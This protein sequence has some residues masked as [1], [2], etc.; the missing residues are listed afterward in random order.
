MP[1]LEVDR[2]TAP[3][4]IAS[5]VGDCAAQYGI[6]IVPLCKALDLD[7]NTF[8][9]LTGRVSLDRLCRL[10]ETCALISGDEA[11]GLKCCDHFKP[12]ASGPYGYGLLS[13]PTALDFFRFLG[14]HQG[15]VASK[16]FCLFAMGPNGA[17]L[18]FSYSPLILKR[19]QYLDMVAGLIMARLRGILG[20]QI[21]AVEIGL[22]R[23][24]PRNPALYRERMSRR[25]SFGKRINTLRLPSELYAVPNPRGDERLFKLMDLQCRSLRP[26]NDSEV[27]FADELKD[28]ILARMAD[29]DIGLKEVADYF[30]MSERTLQRRLAGMGTSLNDL[31]DEIRRELAGKLLAETELT[32]TEI[33]HKLGYSAP[34][35]FTRSMVRWFGKSPRDYRRTSL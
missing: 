11:F 6:D 31:R 35:A 14:E 27:G 9:D 26:G 32:A 2:Y 5:A 33:A 16:S 18:S 20:N 29:S 17:E 23:Q 25:I 8:F 15:Y 34:S 4:G 22:E 7:P 30:R 13:A 3:S 12:G 1:H 21:D 28:Y 24:K 19:D 10:L